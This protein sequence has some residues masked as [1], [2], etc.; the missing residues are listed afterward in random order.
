MRS[1][2]DKSYFPVM[3]HFLPTNMTKAMSKK[4]DIMNI[5]VRRKHREFSDS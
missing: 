4:A 5:N 3:K 1:K 2:A